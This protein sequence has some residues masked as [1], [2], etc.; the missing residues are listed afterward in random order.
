MIIIIVGIS[1]EI[2]TYCIIS[3]NIHRTRYIVIYIC[4]T[5]CI[6]FKKCEIRLF[7]FFNNGLPLCMN[8]D[9]TFVFLNHPQLTYNRH[10]QRL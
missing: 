3:R 7:L 8:Q 4:T 2:L 9:L 10:S 1:L 5:T 6:Y